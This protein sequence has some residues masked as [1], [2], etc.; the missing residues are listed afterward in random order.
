MAVIMG[1]GQFF[2]LCRTFKVQ[3]GANIMIPDSWYKYDIGYLI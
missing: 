1:L 2:S 3:V